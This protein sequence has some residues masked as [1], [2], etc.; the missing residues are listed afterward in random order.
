MLVQAIHK[1]LI[2]KNGQTHKNHKK[3]IRFE[4]ENIKICIIFV[5]C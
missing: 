3:F 5:N 4:V 1:N 2:I